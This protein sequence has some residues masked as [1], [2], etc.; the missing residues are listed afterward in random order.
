M[1]SNPNNLPLNTIHYLFP[2]QHVLVVAVKN[3]Q[4]SGDTLYRRCHY[5]RFPASQ[6]PFGLPWH[7]QCQPYTV[8][9]LSGRSPGP[10]AAAIAVTGALNAAGYTTALSGFVDPACTLQ[11]PLARLDPDTRPSNRTA[12]LI[13]VGSPVTLPPPGFRPVLA[14]GAAYATFHP[15][16][17]DSVQELLT[18]P[19][20]EA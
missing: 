4:I 19:G 15:A 6:R 18:P 13:I 3:L 5:C 9:L 14:V 7:H 11:R 2:P 20:S 8:C 16:Y 1:K 10:A 17:P 12:Y